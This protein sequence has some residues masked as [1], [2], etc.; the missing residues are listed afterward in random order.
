LPLA[1]VGYAAQSAE[2]SP[3]G[4]IASLAAFWYGAEM[5]LIYIAG[6][7]LTALYPLHAAI[8]DL[9][10]PAL[11]ID[12]WVG[13]DLTWRGP[14]VSVAAEAHNAVAGDVQRQP[15]V[16]PS[17]TPPQLHSGSVTSSPQYPS[18]S[19]KRRRH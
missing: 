16:Q 5:V 12:G 11:W 17:T 8:R 7:P 15:I 18:T 4:V 3:L 6:W 1:A 14:Q 13:T 2:V 19:K 9:V 10:L